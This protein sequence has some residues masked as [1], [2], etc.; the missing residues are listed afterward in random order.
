MR[1]ARWGPT[2]PTADRTWLAAIKD[3][4]FASLRNVTQPE[5]RWTD[6]IS[7]GELIRA[8]IDERLEVDPAS[9]RSS[10]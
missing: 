3:Q 7:R 5:K 4:T 9:V 1:V 2:G 10:V 8:G 6:A